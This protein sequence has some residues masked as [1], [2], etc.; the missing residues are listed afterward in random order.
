[1]GSHEAIASLKGFV[2][3]MIAD[4]VKNRES[5]S[6]W[7]KE[8]EDQ[9]ANM[10]WYEKSGGMPPVRSLV[11]AFFHPE[12]PLMGLNY[13]PL[14]HNTLHAFDNG[15]TEPLRHCRGI[16]F[17]ISTPSASLLALPYRKFFNIGEH[18]ETKLLALPDE[19]FDATVKSDGHLGII[20]PSCANS[21]MLTTRGDFSSASSKLGNAMLKRYIRKYH[22]NTKYPDIKITLLV[23]IVHPQTKVHV[24]YGNRKEFILTG[25]FNTGTLEDYDYDALCRF[26]E[27]LGLR[28][29]ERW[30]G[31]SLDDLAK[32]MKDRSITNQEG[33]VVRFKSG[34]RVKFKFETY[35]G[36]MVADKL[37]YPYLMKRFIG[38]NLDRMIDTLPEEIY[39]NALEMLGE[40]LLAVSKGKTQKESWQQLYSLV[41]EDKQT[42]SFKEACRNFVKSMSKE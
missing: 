23:E 26:G 32:L 39:G 20:F 38:G 18:P 1:M 41:P 13:S 12:L 17:D 40:M 14:A 7:T 16:I 25:A 24:D 10:F 22:W 8:H 15:W 4:G 19:P 21:L 33:Y 6:Q 9:M 30:T 5:Y 3:M 36:Q 42:P 37:S 31:N 2:S 27:L 29:A 34:L 11:K 28:V 35:I